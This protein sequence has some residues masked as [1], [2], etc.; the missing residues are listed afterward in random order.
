MDSSNVTKNRYRMNTVIRQKHKKVQRSKEIWIENR[1][2]RNFRTTDWARAIDQVGS[3]E[4]WSLSKKPENRI[5]IK[6]ADF[7]RSKPFSKGID[8]SDRNKEPMYRQSRWQTS[9]NW[10]IRDDGRHNKQPDI[11]LEDQK[12]VSLWK[13][14]TWKTNWNDTWNC[15][16]KQTKD[17]FMKGW[18]AKDLCKET[19]TSQTI[20]N[21][22]RSFQKTGTRNWPDQMEK[23]GRVLW[24]HIDGRQAAKFIKP[25]KP[26]IQYKNR[27]PKPQGCWTERNSSLS[28]W[29]PEGWSS[30]SA[31][32][33]PA[34]RGNPARL[35]SFLFRTQ[36]S[37]PEHQPNVSL[38]LSC[39]SIWLST[40]SRQARN[41][42]PD[43][44]PDTWLDQQAIRIL[45]AVWSTGP[46]AHTK[47]DRSPFLPAYR[48]SGQV[49]RP[50][51]NSP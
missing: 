28:I 37:G 50:G 40:E 7:I 17:P 26:D 47:A 23:S 36:G 27:Y 1:K 25:I 11:K 22:Q 49:L 48:H 15:V 24:S 41:D 12:K 34:D 45:Q 8:G 29:K 31:C 42:I 38:V 19:E 43:Q 6:K 21:N 35:N 39:Q 2:T 32:F 20:I 33:L 16:K 5:K 30:L 46:P 9:W 44:P 13:P 3:G 14:E 10:E 4:Q 51:N 18:K